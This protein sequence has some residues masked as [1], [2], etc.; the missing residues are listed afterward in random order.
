MRWKGGLA[1]GFEALACDLALRPGHRGASLSHLTRTAEVEMRCARR[2]KRYPEVGGKI[3]HSKLTPGV[4]NRLGARSSSP[5]PRPA[6]EELALRLLSIARHRDRSR[7]NYALRPDTRKSRNK[8]SRKMR[9]FKGVLSSR[10]KRL[11][12][13]SRRVDDGIRSPKKLPRSR[14]NSSL[15]PPTHTRLR[16]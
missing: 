16:S 15:R 8:L 3:C 2:G 4:F 7:S 11:R 9:G 10:R 5:S 1:G 13:W 6:P 12:C 14:Q